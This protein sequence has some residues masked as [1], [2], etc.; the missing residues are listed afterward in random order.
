MRAV[1]ITGAFT[2]HSAPA[3]AIVLT[4]AASLVGLLF[5]SLLGWP[6]WRIALAMLLPWAPLLTQETVWTYRHYHWLALFYVLAVTQT[7]HFFEHVAQ[8]VQIHVL[9]LT[10]DS[11]RGVFGALDIEWVHFIFNT[12][13]IVLIPIL[14]WQFKRNSWLWVAAILSGWHEIEHVVIMST[15]LATGLVGTPGLLARG[16]LVG[17]GLPLGRADLH[18]LYNLVETGP[19]VVAFVGQLQEAMACVCS[20]SVKTPA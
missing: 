1:Q 20:R 6:L 2:I 4:G 19:L 12:W 10:G 15:Y 13:V 3:R 17:G 11:A 16:G 18:F 14:L 5:A 8:M 7:G 9:R